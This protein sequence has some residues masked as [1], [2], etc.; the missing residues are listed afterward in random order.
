MDKSHNSASGESRAKMLHTTA[1]AV[2]A[3]GPDPLFHP[4]PELEK[5]FHQFL[6]SQQMVTR[7]KSSSPLG[8]FPPSLAA[9]FQCLAMATPVGPL[10]SADLRVASSHEWENSFLTGYTPVWRSPCAAAQ[11]GNQPRPC[12][13]P[14]LLACTIQVLQSAEIGL[15]NKHARI[16]SRLHLLPDQSENGERGGQ[17]SGRTAAAS[18]SQPAYVSIC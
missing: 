18:F 4:L 12:R 13:A 16:F 8:G 3:E 17:L 11:L 9:D 14:V 7:S 6:N 1:E 10:S 2:V 15:S 5:H